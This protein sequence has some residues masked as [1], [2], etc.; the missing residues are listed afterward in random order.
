[1]KN[2]LM[3]CAIVLGL[4]GI[5]S[6]E[7]PS[8][9]AAEI[10]AELVELKNLLEIMHE[11]IERL[12]RRLV[13]VENHSQKSLPWQRE[14]PFFWDGIDRKRGDRRLDYPLKKF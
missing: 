9:E 1:M 12:E 10:R 2:S 14:Q 6:A 3:T 5:A 8:T 7:E 13:A 11:R 4:T